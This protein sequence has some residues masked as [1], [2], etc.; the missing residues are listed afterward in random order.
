MLFYSIGLQKALVEVKQAIEPYQGIAQSYADDIGVI[1]PISSL[2]PVHHHLVTILQAHNL[3]VNISKTRVIVG[4]VPQMTSSDT[5]TVDSD[6]NWIPLPE[7]HDSGT[8]LGVMMGDPAA[9]NASISSVHNSI[10]TKIEMIKDIPTEI[11]FFLLKYCINTMAIY[12]HRVYAPEVSKPH[13]VDDMVDQALGNMLNVHL[14]VT[15]KVIR[16]L[17]GY[18]GGLGI[19]CHST[20]FACI[21][22]DTLQERCLVWL[23][24]YYTTLVPLYH[25]M[26]VVFPIAILGKVDINDTRAPHLRT[27]KLNKQVYGGLLDHLSQP[28]HQHLHPHAAMLRSSAFRGS[29]QIYEISYL[30]KMLQP[31]IFNEAIRARLLIPAVFEPVNRCLCGH[32]DHPALLPSYH[33]LNCVKM[34][35]ERIKRHDGIRD[36]LMRFIKSVEPRAIIVK[37]ALLNPDVNNERSDL[38]ATLPSTTY[39]IDVTI[40][41]PAQLDC[42]P[43][44]RS[45]ITNASGFDEEGF[46]TFAIRSTATIDNF[47]A[48]NAEKEK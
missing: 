27:R 23:K 30:N 26:K 22:F 5:T 44:L 1:S 47:A 32:Y 10:S 2:R 13:L 33:P 4:S 48:T 15:S 28:A 25:R 38:R 9:V 14:S 34:S 7:L 11:A 24:Q 35:Y 31:H 36:A 8:L 16:A 17:P 45:R 46:N 18:L 19:P 41:N 37:E 20:H 29:G 6:S 43:S 42:L 12:Q 3:P 39:Q 40:T 21:L